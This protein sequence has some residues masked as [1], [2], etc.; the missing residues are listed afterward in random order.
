MPEYV[1]HSLTKQQLESA[2]RRPPHAIL[3]TGPAGLGKASVATML[4]GMIM[5]TREDELANYPHIRSI[6]PVDRKAIGIEV[7]R[8]LEHFMSLKIAGSQPVRRVVIIEDAHLL[9]TEAQNALLKTLE[10]P[11]MDAVL[12]LTSAQEQALL[13]T[14]RSRVQT[15]AI[16]RPKKS[17][18]KEYFNHKAGLANIEQA[19]AVS[20]GLPGLTH[21]LLNADDEHPLVGAVKVARQLLQQTV[22]ERLLMV[23][24][25]VKQKELT[26]D[27]CYVLGQM[28]SLSLAKDSSSVRWQRVMRAAYAAE[29]GLLGSAQ[30][31]LVLTNLML[32]L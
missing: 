6:K 20:G 29:E 8:E 15:I 18:L 14:I 16:K 11:P 28:A 24:V 22:F 19:I 25:L 12:I 3:L 13:P 17:E 23:D 27:L 26:R 32:Q 9:T 10:E 5:N 31:K 7:V 1:I 2:S 21:A 30:P 4:A